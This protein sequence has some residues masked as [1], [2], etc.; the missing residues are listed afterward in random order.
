MNLALAVAIVCGSFVI[1]VV[2]FV[3]FWRGGRVAQVIMLLRFFRYWCVRCM[4]VVL[5]L[6]LS[7]FIYRVLCYVSEF[8]IEIYSGEINYYIL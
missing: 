6:V 3:I 1:A 4:V 7:L 5:E 2:V 8:V